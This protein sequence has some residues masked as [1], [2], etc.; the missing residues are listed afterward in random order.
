MRPITVAVAEPDPGRRIQLEHFLKS[1]DHNIE[2]LTDAISNYGKKNERKLK[3]RYNLPFS[4]KTAARIKRLNPRVLIVNTQQLTNECCDLLV[5][6][7]LLCPDTLSIVLIK[8]QAGDCQIIKALKSG[9][10]GIVDCSERSL[11]LSKIIHTVDKG[12]PWIPR[13]I[14]TKIMEK[15]LLSTY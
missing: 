11:D 9:A 1:R 4:T 7:R 5:E 12:E 14:L 13:K 15:I 6:V 3:P 2:V 8:E 10:K